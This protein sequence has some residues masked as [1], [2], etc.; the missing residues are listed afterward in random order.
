MIN[1]IKKT[2]L[3]SAKK[4]PHVPNQYLGYSLQATRF[5][6]K[7]LEVDQD[8]SVSLE[9]FEDVGAES[10]SGCRVVEQ[11]KSTHG[12]NP[13]SDR[14]DDLWKTFSNWIDSIRQKELDVQKTLFEI[15]VSQPKDGAI[16]NDF[17]NATSI[18]EAIKAFLNARNV[19]WGT[20]PDY[21]LKKDVSISLSKYLENVFGADEDIALQ[22]IRNFRINCGS[23]SPIED[24]KKEL[25]SKLVHPDILDDVFV[26]SLGW[27]KKHIDNLIEQ[28]KPAVISVEAFR[29]AIISFMRRCDRQR[30]LRSFAKDPTPEQ[31]N[32]EL[33]CKYIQQLEI[34]N[35]DYDDKI[36]AVISFLKAS[37]DRAQWSIKGWVHEESFTEFENVLISF[38]R[39]LKTRDYAIYKQLSDEEKGKVLYA[40]CLLSQAKIEGLETPPH[41]TPGSF[42]ALSNKETIGWH[43]NYPHLLKEYCG[44]EERNGNPESGN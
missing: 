17:S 36:S 7:L 33:P 11:T 34:I 3:S 8:W 29:N 9:V 39:N 22:L 18:D 13:V 6:A 44:K 27:I 40:D 35:S 1:K 24:L 23:G 2:K 26:Y 15:Y 30:I 32:V 20:P 5:L 37:T 28:N 4:S 12:G 38:W 43:P 21:S 41:F 19:L 25:G 42:H 31:I 14:A 10:S 16:V